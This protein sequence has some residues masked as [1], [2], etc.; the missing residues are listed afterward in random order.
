MQVMGIEVGYNAEEFGKERDAD[1][2]QSADRNL[3][4]NSKKARSEGKKAKSHKEEQFEIVDGIVYGPEI[5][6]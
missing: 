6:V 3:V 4:Y 2:V 1:R 5:D